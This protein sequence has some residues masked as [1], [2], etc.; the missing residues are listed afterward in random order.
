ARLEIP[1]STLKWRL[2]EG[3]KALRARLQ[4]QAEAPLSPSE[5][6]SGKERGMVTDEVLRVH[7]DSLRRVP[8]TREY[9]AIL[10]DTATQ[11]ILPISVTEAEYSALEVALQVRQ[12]DAAMVSAP[13]LSQRLLDAFGGHLTQVAINALVGNTLY[14]SATITHGKR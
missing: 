2:F 1:V 10:R 11:H 12:D 8:F 14:A 6:Q 7:V 4:P 9:L 13:D 5:S 3:R